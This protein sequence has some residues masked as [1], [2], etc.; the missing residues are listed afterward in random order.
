[1]LQ[2]IIAQSLHLLNSKD[3]LG[4]IAA[5]SGR[6]SVLA[7]DAKRQHEEK[8]REL[9]FWVYSRPP[10]SE[11]LGLALAHIKKYSEKPK[12]AYEDIVW[13]LLNTKEFLFNH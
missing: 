5:G 2:R 6:A 9:Y 10:D 13:A 3:V 7:S 11:E 12:E 1:M 8:I 4:K